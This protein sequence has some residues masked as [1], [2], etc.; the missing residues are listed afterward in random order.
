MNEKKILVIGGAGFIGSNLIKSLIKNKKNKVVSLDNYSTGSIKNHFENVEYF[1]GEAKKINT[2]IKIKPHLIFHLGEYSRVEK[3]F[4]DIDIVFDN[5]YLSIYPVLKFAN[6]NQSKLIYCGSSTKFDVEKGFSL[7]PYTWTKSIN[8]ELIKAYSNWFNIK[9]AIVYFYNVYGPN[10]LEDTYGTLIGKFKKAMREGKT[11]K[12]VLPGTQKRNFTHV[13]DIVDGL[14]L[15]SKSGEGDNFGIGCEKSYSIIEVAKMFGG[16][17]QFLE[18]RKG[19]RSDSKLVIDKTKKLGWL[20]KHN[21][22]DYIN[23]L[24]ENDWIDN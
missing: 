18:E 6:D 3:S 1:N 10:E 20:A 16:N 11:L 14:I 4:E 19:N 24:R 23:E 2:I 5:N 21:L 13:N 9:Y 7:S 17:F 12:V 15:I 22:P 8:S